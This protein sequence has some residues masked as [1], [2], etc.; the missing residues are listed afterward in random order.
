MGHH[1]QGHGLHEVTKV[2]GTDVFEPYTAF[3][4]PLARPNENRDKVKAEPTADEVKQEPHEAKKNS[5]TSSAVF[6]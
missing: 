2:L 3:L 1:K 6:I 4:R 5:P